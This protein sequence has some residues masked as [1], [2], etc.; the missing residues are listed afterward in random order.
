MGGGRRAGGGGPLGSEGPPGGGGAPGEGGWGRGCSRGPGLCRGCGN[1]APAASS[2]EQRAAAERAPSDRLHHS[3]LLP[4]R[5]QLHLPP[6]RQVLRP[7][8]PPREELP[9][10]EV[11]PHQPAAPQEEAQ[12]GRWKRMARRAAGFW[13]GQ[14]DGRAEPRD[15]GG[16]MLPV[17][18]WAAPACHMVGRLT[19]RPFW[20]RPLWFPSSPFGLRVTGRVNF[21]GLALAVVI[22]LCCAHKSQQGRA[23]QA[24]CVLQR[25]VKGG[26]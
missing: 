17:A 6:P 16:C 20:R 13:R 22:V 14:R 18:W 9:Q 24:L 3:P 8:A 15:R 26:D 21:V 23:G 7:P 5:P 11:R 10:E 19:R 25:V 4:R 2:R 1:G 12:V